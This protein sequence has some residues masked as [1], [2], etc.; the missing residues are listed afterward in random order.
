MLKLPAV[1]EGV[2]IIGWTT[3]SASATLGAVLSVALLGAVTHGGR[4]PSDPMDGEL[5]DNALV[6]R[7]LEGDATAYRGLVE[8]Y[9]TRIY[10]VIFGMVRNP[11]DAR[12]LTQDAF[13][14]AYKNLERFGGRA[15]FYTWVCRIAMNRAID[16]LRRQKHR[17]AEAFDENIASHDESGVISLA[18]HRDDPRRNLERKRLRE[19][20]AEE[21]AQL[22][23][24]HRQVIIL[25]EIDGLSY[26]EIS[27]VMDI[28]VGTVM[29]RLYTARKKLQTALK[30]V[31]E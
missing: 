16:H 19:R 10:R 28:P 18:H 13:V 24:E 30:T 2:M 11:E 8:R 23:E 26:K 29:S 27:A 12:E 25:R 7:T 17:Q 22:P 5:D 6:A 20:I 3:F 21:V 9:Q 31:R 14:R 4:T 1:G 15:S